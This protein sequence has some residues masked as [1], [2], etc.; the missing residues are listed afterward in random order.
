[1]LKRVLPLL[2][3]L[4]LV[5]APV[6]RADDRSVY[7]AW[8]AHDAQF[9]RNA[10]KMEENYQSGRSPR[11]KAKR[12]IAL[13]DDTRELLAKNT[14]GV[15]AE[16]ASSEKGA[17]ARGLALKSNA[18]FGESLLIARKGWRL[19]VD[20]ASDRK[21]DRYLRRADVLLDESLSYAKRARS[22]FKEAGVSVQ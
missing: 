15:K 22:A 6:V 10:E 8:N 4:A 2:A 18:R 12:L 11:R 16:Q 14:A 5:L 19:F 20:G 9:D 17:E 7:D 21:V 1:M 13:I 3:V